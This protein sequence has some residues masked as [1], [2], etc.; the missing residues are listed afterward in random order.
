[1]VY[2]AGEHIKKIYRDLNIWK[3]GN[4]V[5]S[6]ISKSV[7]LIFFIWPVVKVGALSNIAKNSPS[8]HMETGA[9]EIPQI[10]HLTC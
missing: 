9:T 2:F 8:E 10:T 7:Y 5:S 3:R 6:K 4:S 1:M